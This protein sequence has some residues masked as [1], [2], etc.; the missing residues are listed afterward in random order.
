MYLTEDART[1][2]TDKGFRAA[3]TN[4][5]VREGGWY[6]EVKVERGGGEG[7]RHA[8]GEEKG[9]GEGS[10]CRLGVG[11]REAPLNAPVGYDG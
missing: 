8:K 10:W 11:R 9:E 5:G 6:W 3:R 4:V 7:G 1:V 2:T